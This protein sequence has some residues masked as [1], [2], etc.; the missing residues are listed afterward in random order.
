MKKRTR[1]VQTKARMTKTPSSPGRREMLHTGAQLERIQAIHAAL[2]GGKAV[3]ALKLANALEVNDKT[4]RRDL[5]FMRDRLELPVSEYDPV[6]GGFFYT[7]AVAN[8]PLMQITEGELLALMVARQ[9]VEA[10]RGTPYAHTLERAFA[11]LTAGLGDVVSFSASGAGLP[12]AI[13]FRNVGMAAVN[14]AVFTAASRAVL[15]CEESTFLYQKP[16]DYGPEL[17]R[18]QPYHLACIGGMWY[19][20]GHDL[21]RQAMRTFALPRIHDFKTTKHQFVRDPDF[22]PEKYFGDSF[23]ML[24]GE[25]DGGTVRVRIAF[26]SY[27]SDLVRE[28]FW[29]TS[30]VITERTNA[31][32]SSKGIELEL[33]VRNTDEVRRWVLGWGER[34]RVIEPP[35]LVAEMRDVAARLVK[36]YGRRKR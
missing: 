3:N 29:H 35:E 25:G 34:A 1:P 30:Q 26:D 16:D 36:I 4:I 6:R 11:K 13:S 2:A 33:R 31:D 15:K 21:D 5:A 32:G 23:G 19:L 7:E 10:Y 18:V 24:R 22:S 14:T 28:R 17:R 8:L 27:A 12:G 20:V 9:A